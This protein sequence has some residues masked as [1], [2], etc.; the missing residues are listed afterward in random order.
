MKP[1]S[2]LWRVC[3]FLGLRVVTTEYRDG[4]KYTMCEY[5]NEMLPANYL[6]AKFEVER[7]GQLGAIFNR[8]LDNDKKPEEIP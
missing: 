7:A 4:R 2:W 6:A 5:T 1:Y 3:G 8:I